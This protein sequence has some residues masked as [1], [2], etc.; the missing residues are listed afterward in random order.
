L[1]SVV[2][3]MNQVPFLLPR[4]ERLLQRIERQVSKHARRRPPADD[5]SRENVDDESDINYIRPHRNVREIRSPKTMGSI[6]TESLM[7][8]VERVLVFIL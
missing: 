7:R 3:M 2:R 6:S 8:E 5:H 4:P 1:R